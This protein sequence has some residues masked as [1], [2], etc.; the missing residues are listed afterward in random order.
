LKLPWN[1][2]RRVLHQEEEEEE[3][4]QVNEGKEN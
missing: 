2:R 4:E 1:T 3:E